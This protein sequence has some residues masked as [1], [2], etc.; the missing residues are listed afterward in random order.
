MGFAGH[1][2]THF[3]NG[4]NDVAGREWAGS[5]FPSTP[6]TRR[7]IIKGA[8]AAGGAFALG[9]VVSACGGDDGGGGTTTGGGDGPK[10][11]GSLKAG[12]VG[13]SAKDTLDAHV[14]VNEPEIA[15]SFQLYNRLLEYTP[16]Y[17]LDNVLA[18]SVESSADANVW[19]VRL[20]PDLMYSNGKPVTADDVVFSYNRIIDPDIPKGVVA[21]LSMLKPSGIKR[22][23]ELTV[24]FTLETPNAVFPDALAYRENSI[25]REDYDPKNSIGTG[26]FQL[27]S[28]SPGEQTVYARNENFFGEGPYLDELTIVQFADPTARVNAL[29]SGAINHADQGGQR[30]GRGHPGHFGVQDLGD[31]GRR[32]AAFDHAHGSEA[33][34]RCAHAAGFPPD[35]RPSAD[36]RP[37][38]CRLRMGRQRYVW[39]VRPRG[40][41]KTH[42][43]V[44]KTSSRPATTG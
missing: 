44:S 16:D 14:V 24:K 23:D 2:V 18:E 27:V 37:G 28:F 15:N 38:L 30:P 26:L 13:G 6:L 11:G 34:R 43:S 42:R 4:D 22:V 32:L 9:P 36:D 12:I 1:F 35:G 5:G 8:A 31:Q 25:V 21:S 20:K 17:K 19:T 39:A 7:Q 33:V 3:V 41:Q 29:L 10:K 40:I